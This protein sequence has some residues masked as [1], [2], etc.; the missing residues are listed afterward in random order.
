MRIAW[1]AA[2]AVTVI[3]GAAFAAA[4]YD[5]QLAT[6]AAR[7]AAEAKAPQAVSPLAAL[8]GL[9]ELV[10]PAALEAALRPGIV[11]GAHPLVAAQAALILAHLLE[12]R[13][14]AGEAAALRAP[15]GLLSHWF[16]IGPF[17]DG[18]ASFATR[19]PPESEKAPPEVGRSYPGK[20]REVSWRAGDAAMRDGV[21]YLDGLLRPDTQAVAYVVAYVRSDRARPAALRLGSA[22][23]LKVWWNGA[24]VLSRD[25]AR[26]AALDQDAVG[27]RLQRGWN[28]LMIKTVVTDGAWRLYA[29]LT[30][31]SGA[32]LRLAETRGT[33]P[34]PATWAPQAGAAGTAPR[35]ATLDAQLAARIA[36]AGGG[37]AGAAAWLDRGRALA[38]LAPRDRDDHAPADAFAR[39]LALAPSLPALLAAADAAANDDERR[40]FLEQALALRSGGRESLSRPGGRCS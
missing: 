17:G 33:A 13:G 9:D 1:V 11:P 20:L 5:D 36:R 31:P 21:L 4:P 24:E 25:V 3:S 27:V 2:L 10:A 34:P 32:P 12:Q 28:R 18:R 23:P 30:E 14:E 37:A 40:R 7:L 39:A 29:R 38:W 26:P 8:A 15:L 6:E 16:V 22:G 35:I 19:F